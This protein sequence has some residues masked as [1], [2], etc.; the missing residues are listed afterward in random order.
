[1]KKK[2]M[3]ILSIIVKVTF[4]QRRELRNS[5]I[6]LLEC[7][8]VFGQP[9]NPGLFPPFDPLLLRLLIVL[10]LILFFLKLFLLLTFTLFF[11]IL[12]FFFVVLIAMV[13][14]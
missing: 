9:R 13:G 3:S 4:L 14:D 11:I 8:A 12:Y 1:M 10:I 7:V 5:A 2:K 6:D